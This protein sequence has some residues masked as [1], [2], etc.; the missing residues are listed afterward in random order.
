MSYAEYEKEQKRT[1]LAEVDEGFVS[2]EQIDHLQYLVSGNPSVRRVLEIGFNAGNSAAAMLSARPDVDIVS[3]DIGS[4]EYVSQAK[5]LIDTMFPG[6]HKLIIGDSTYT[7]PRFHV[8]ET[9]MF[10]I[11]FIDGGH[12]GEVP[13]LDIK[14]SCKL[15]RKGGMIVVDDMAYADVRLGLLK[16]ADE[17]LIKPVGSGNENDADRDW[18]YCIRQ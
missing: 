15:V 16:S 5:R 4:H 8:P 11:A 17:G 13:Y 9:E 10:D 6:R 12:H 18:A 2:M 14:N 7:V 3:F 1:F